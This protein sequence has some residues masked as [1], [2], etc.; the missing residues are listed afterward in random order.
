MLQELPSV[1]RPGDLIRLRQGD[2]RVVS[3]TAHADCAA[4]AVT[5][6]GLGNI[7]HRRVFLLPFD[8]PAALTRRVRPRL[9][10]PDVWLQALR[11]LASG[12]A[13]S[14]A[15]RAPVDARIDLLP[16]Q[17][18]PALALVRGLTSR[19]LVADAVG[20]GKTIQAGLALAELRAR[21][22]AARALILTP[23]GLR[24][25]WVREL[26]D[27][28]SISAVLL[29]AA[30]LR[31]AVASLPVHVNPW[32][33]DPVVVA[34]LDFIKQPEVN[35]A[36]DSI[37]WDLLV[38]DEAHIVATA[39][40]RHLAV[41][42]LGARARW[43]VLLTATPHAGDDTAFASLCR[44]GQLDGRRPMI[45]FRR[46][47]R[48]AGVARDRRVRLL[49]IVLTPAEAAL[50]ALLD[51][52]SQLVWRQAAHRTGADAR[53][54]MIVL[55][56]RALSS[57]WAVTRSIEHRLAHLDGDDAPA[58]EQLLLPL[59]DEGESDADD[60]VPAPALACRGLPD[61]AMERRHLA[62]ILDA[63][64]AA[65]RHDSKLAALVRLLTRVDEPAIVFT[66][67]RDTAVAIADTLAAV[68]PAVVLHGGLDRASRR[69]VERRFHG[70]QARV[71]VA[72]DAAG[73]GLN[74]QATCRFVVNLELPWNPMRLE[75]R[76]GRVDRIG[77]TRRVHVVNLVAR[78]TGE[79]LILGRLVSRIARVR[80][81]IGHTGDPIGSASQ[82]AAAVI[83]PDPS[84]ADP[85]DALCA[86][87]L[88]RAGSIAASCG[89][90]P[91][92][93][94]LTGLAITEAE[95]LR[96]AREVL[97]PTAQTARRPLTDLRAQLEIT[98]PWAHV[99]TRVSC[100]APGALCLFRV[101]LIDG[102]GGLQEEMIVP[103]H[104]EAAFDRIGPRAAKSLRDALFESD[105]ALLPVL[106]ERARTEAL[107][108]LSVLAPDAAA[109]GHQ[110]R[111]REAAIAS[112]IRRRLRPE[113]AGLV[114]AG[115]FDQRELRQAASRRLAWARMDRELEE[116]RAGLRRSAVLS[117]AGEPEAMLALWIAPACPPERR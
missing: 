37:V 105:G 63:A 66:E 38:V 42:G 45:M 8:R 29:D 101:R 58:D 103:V 71:L 88:P 62:E 69:D 30:A 116:R 85:V 47:A 48:Q 34:S 2:W 19:V 86:A 79:E 72:T 111:E 35:R 9:V 81:V 78:C 92:P 39:R 67:F 28:F 100:L 12:A 109:A 60:L 53:L 14:G 114:Q 99:V 102:R 107:A 77:Q 40:E 56:K 87:E 83:A 52:Y 73:Q 7:G 89:A 64:R 110:T 82:I 15:L 76:I 4:L 115:L 84:V 10:G 106:R 32:E 22:V 27:R 55:R 16:Y 20:L 96:R 68:T 95:R 31:R 41:E 50:H 54:A 44:L 3:V 1:P 65:I 43:I 18:E 61:A 97:R 51:R 11:I 21:D 57:V 13:A 26:A 117:V 90:V 113:F 98:A 23:A 17:L 91:P 74:L 108:R 104:A 46:T 80:D 6:V 75:Q 25:Q 24:E 5:G 59:M 33:V 70:G 93:S 36:L 49:R 94:D 112:F